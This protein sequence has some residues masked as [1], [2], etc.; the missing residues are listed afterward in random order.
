MNK[1]NFTLL[2]AFTFLLGGMAS[3]QKSLTAETGLAK[4]QFREGKIVKQNNHLNSKAAIFS[5]DFSGG[6]LPA[7]W[8]NIDNSTNGFVW[9]FTNPGARTINTTTGATGFA[10]ADSDNLGDVGGEDCDLITPTID[11]SALTVVKLRFEHYFYAGYGGAGVVSVSGNNGSNWTD[12]ESFGAAST[13]NAAVA[14]YDISAVAAG[15]T[16]VLIKWNW[17]GDWSW[18]WAIDDVSVFEPEANDLAVTAV[19]PSGLIGHFGVTPK[20]TVLNNGGTDQSTYSVLLEDGAGY[21]ETFNSGATLAA[22]ASLEILFP[23]WIPAV[24]VY[25]LTATVTLAGDGNNTNDILA[26]TGEVVDGLLW[27]AN[28]DNTGSENG[29]ISTDLGGITPGLIETADDFELPA[30]TWFIDQITSTGFQSAG[31]L[32]G[33]RVI[34]YADNAGTPGD[35]VFEEVV[36]ETNADEQ[37]LTFTN[38]LVLPGETKYWLMIAGV[39]P[40][41]TAVSQGRW[42]WFTWDNLTGY[43]ANLRDQPAVFGVGTDWNA[44]S[45]I[46]VTGA[47]S[48]NFAIYGHVPS[49]SYDITFNINMLG[50]NST[51]NAATQEVYLSGSVFNP[52]WPKPG[53]LPAAQM[54]DVDAD[55]IY[56]ITLTLDAG[57]YEY[58]TFYINTGTPS[59]DN[60]YTGNLPLTVV[61]DATIDAEW[62]WASGVNNLNS[63]ISIY[64]NPSNGVFTVNTT[65]V[66][67]L[68]VLDLTGKVISTQVLNGNGSVSINNAGVYF[69]KFSNANNSFVQRVIVK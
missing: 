1:K 8:Q 23:E 32:T 3:A 61:G 50:T 19:A 9:V 17:T 60:S 65:E 36:A 25:T 59:W 18:Y 68:Q 29:I 28:I 2:I 46:G 6:A 31:T 47:A 56:T 45:A 27:G 26:S 58:K 10:I 33:F 16:S 66:Y 12:L 14:E 40:T 15:S 43:E 62:V 5:E 39:Y 24:G 42:N 53:E 37:I 20:V 21:S 41:A 51:F 22:G 30:G 13:A 67:N 4:K 48:T 34:I 35:V 52:V 64:P 57:D 55:G 49:T 44:L 54:T 7:D 38:P 63:G 11:C 69:L